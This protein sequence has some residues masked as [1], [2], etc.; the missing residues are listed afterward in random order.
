[1]FFIYEK[2][3][4]WRLGVGAIVLLWCM[5]SVGAHAGLLNEYVQSPPRNVRREL[6]TYLTSHGIR[7]ARADYWTAYHTT[8]F[9]Q[10]QVII[11]SSD[12]IRIDLYQELV[13]KAGPQAV[14]LRQKPCAGAGGQE[15][16]A[17]HYWICP[18]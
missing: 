11:A 18:Q 6:A 10:E 14:R 8:F 9:A 15:A 13:E 2:S 7:Y 1:L 5:V 4:P 3:R 17:G 12:F 16:I